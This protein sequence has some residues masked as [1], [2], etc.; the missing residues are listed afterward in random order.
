MIN[1]TEIQRPET[2]ITHKLNIILLSS[3]TNSTKQIVLPEFQSGEFNFSF[4]LSDSLFLLCG[5][6]NNVGISFLIIFFFFI[7]LYSLTSLLTIKLL[8]EQTFQF[9]SDWC[10]R[11]ILLCLDS[12]HS[13][14]YIFKKM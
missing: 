5:H 6:L 3:Q 13:T 4:P 1:H 9:C 11:N 12:M 7:P 2:Q 14:C 8:R 10:I